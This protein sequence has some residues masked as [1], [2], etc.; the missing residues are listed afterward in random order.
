[1]LNYKISVMILITIVIIF[2]IKVISA[3]VNVER[4]CYVHD[5]CEGCLGANYNCAWCTDKTYEMPRR[6]STRDELEVNN[7]SPENIWV[8][9]QEVRI[10]DAEELQD[11]QNDTNRS[12]QV[13]PQKIAIRLVKSHTQQFKL[14][15]RPALNNPLDLYYLMDL[16]WTMRDDKKTLVKLGAKLSEAL[17]NLTANYR[18]GFGSFADKPTMPMIMPHLK[19][20]P[21]ASEGHTCEPTYSFRHNLQLTNDIDKFVRSVKKSRVTGNLDNL[22]GGLDALMQVIVCP[23]KIGWKEEARKIVILATD[24]FMHF[25]GDGILA[26]INLRNDRKCHLDETGEYTE[27]LK[28]DYPS[29][30]EIYRELVRRKISVIFAVTDNAYETYQQMN[31]LMNGISNVEKLSLDSSNILELIKTSYETFLKRVK[32]TDNT[33]SFIDLKYETNCGG[34]FD[35]LRKQNYCNDLK[36]GQEVEFYINITLNEFPSDGNYSRTIRIED[37]AL[38]EYLELDI[39]IQEPC[40]CDEKELGDETERAMC[41]E[42]GVFNCGMCKCDE[43]WGGAF[44]NC[45]LGTSNSTTAIE[46]ECRQPFK[47]TPHLGPI[48]SDRGECDCG[49]C[50]C[51][52]GYDGKYCECPECIDCD[53]EKADCFCGKCVCKYGWFGKSCNCKAEVDE[54]CKTPN[55][56]ICSNRGECQCGEC[57]CR[58]RFV[59]RFCEIGWEN[60]NKLCQYYEPCVKCMIQQKLGIFI[61]ENITEICSNSEKERFQYSFVTEIN[62]DEARCVVRLIDNNDIK[63][64]HFFSY[65]RP[66]SSK[67]YLSIKI[68]DCTPVN[69]MVMGGFISLFTFLIGLIVLGIYICCTR[70][71]DARE[72]ARFEQQKQNSTLMESPIYENPVRRYL[73]PQL[74]E[75]DKTL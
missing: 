36:M 35:S 62:D 51:Y 2:Q 48:C 22:E 26:G 42:N 54:K 32:F 10:M 20:N 67:N 71:A 73:V 58:D 34:Q 47:S 66:D 38:S 33:P 39:E 68:E 55:G 53:P 13:K 31:V 18:V 29:L 9:K 43:G 46:D 49:V 19:E 45:N 64:D 27:S 8:N 60:E 56:E 14:T 50:Y 52:P 69:T 15:Y 1:M 57:M 16:T 24:G 3:D 37:P 4:Q 6:C 75:D 23:E 65:N 63:C 44:C 28:F 25:A 40:P 11:F 30:E 72:Y 17:K 41:W 21:C 61:C 59:G 74:E 12:I 7:C 5:T 70:L